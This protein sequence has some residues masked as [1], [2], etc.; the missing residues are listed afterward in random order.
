MFFKILKFAETHKDG[1]TVELEN[2]SPVTE[3]IAV[4]YA[5][6]QNCHDEKMPGTRLEPWTGNRG[7]VGLRIRG[8]LLRFGENFSR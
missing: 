4:A 7:M 5:E 3:G 1:F 8:F 2:L 6:T